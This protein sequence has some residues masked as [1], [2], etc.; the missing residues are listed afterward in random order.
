MRA[1]GKLPSEIAE[2]LGVERETEVYQLLTERF[3]K[4]ASYLTSLDRNS[5]LG[6]QFMR[7]EA[8]LAAVWPSAMMGDPKSV[9]EAGDLV[10]K[11]ARLTG[12]EQVDP[13]INKNLVLVMGEKEEDYIASLKATHSD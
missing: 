1:G 12:L 5:L 10:M 11:E 2:V 7:L 4:D 13:V 6:M 9:H 3:E 8:L